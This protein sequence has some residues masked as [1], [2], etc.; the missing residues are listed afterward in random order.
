MWELS[1]MD[2]AIYD[3]AQ[4]VNRKDPFLA[5]VPNSVQWSLAKAGKLPNP[6]FNK[7]TDLYKWVDEKVW[8]Y[9][10]NVELPKNATGKL[11][12]LCFDGIDYFARVWVNGTLIG[13]HEGMFGGPAIEISK[14]IKQT[15][16][17]E[18]VVEVKAGNWGNKG[19]Y[20]PAK[21]G[22]VIR[23]WLVG[24]GNGVEMFFPMGIWRGIR[25]EIFNKNHIE[26]PFLVTKSIEGKTVELDLSFEV[27]IN[28][29]SLLYEIH[30]SDNST[31][32]TSG[33]QKQ[34]IGN[35]SAK[36]EITDESSEIVYSQTIPLLLHEGRNWMRHSIKLSNAK[37]WYPNGMGKASLYGVR[38]SLLTGNEIKDELYF[39]Y[40]IRTIEH[41]PSA[42]PQL[43]DRWYNWQYEVNGQKLFVKGINWMFLDPLLEANEVKYR[44][45]LESAKNAGIQMIRV[46]GSCLIESDTFFDICDELGLMVESEFPL[47]N[48]TAPLYPQEIWE[49]QVVQ[50]IFRLR[51]HPSLAVWSGG[52]EFNAYHEENAVVIGILER[53]VAMFDGTRQFYRTD[54]DGGAVHPYPDFDPVWY[55]IVHGNNPWVGE[56][57]IHSLPEAALFRETVNP[58]ELEGGLGN[59]YKEDFEKTHPEFVHHFTEYGPARVPRM[60]SRASHIIDISD[61]TLDDIT[62]ASQVGAGE[63]YQ[64]MSEKFQSN[65]PVTTGLLPWVLMRTW[66]TAGIQLI[67]G[68]GNAGAPYYFLKRTYESTHVS[69]DIERLIWKAGEEMSLPVTVTHALPKRIENAKISVAIFDDVFNSVSNL[70]KVTNI[71]EGTSVNNEY[72]GKFLIPANYKD[73][74]LFILVEL[75]SADGILISRS[76]YYPRVLKLMDDTTFYNKYVSEPIPWITLD[77]GPWLKPTVANSKTS[78]DIKV[79]GNSP[80]KD[81]NSE[82]QLLVKNTG[83]IPSF[84]TT[85]DV[86]G[87]KRIFYASDNYFWLAP[88][89]EKIIS[90]TLSFRENTLGKKIEVSAKSWNAKVSKVQLQSK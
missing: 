31:L 90:M 75:R 56:A 42:G 26:R 3:L 24:G 54:P 10:K 76:W 74:F 73:R 27:F 50:N 89:E 81:G 12:F 43:S 62:E 47:G 33:D 53:N 85:I 35:L 4:L 19:K 84:M 13:S 17:N 30:P 6:Y 40:G 38:L 22:T 57:G 78:L 20:K 80:L 21:T 1:Y 49:A 44:W 32:N 63:F 23:P 64:I 65:Y 7:N 14:F 88:G 36:L 71:A 8:Y 29:H 77:K 61:P 48:Q 82:I 46:N 60:L 41:L 59:M 28:S 45:L 39:K 51:N 2:S 9:R 72:M 52:N 34:S 16:T 83:K 70:E 37:L 87:A 69:I 68:F 5:E 11:V 15:D 66:P 55:K 18:I 79:I 67:D 25:L 58:A 86:S